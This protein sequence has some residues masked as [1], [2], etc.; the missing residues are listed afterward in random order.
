M[1]GGRQQSYYAHARYY[2]PATAQ[3]LSRDPA[4]AT[5][6]EPYSYTGDNPLNGTDPNGLVEVNTVPSG[7][8]GQTA[9]CWVSRSGSLDNYILENP[10]GASD[11]DLCAQAFP[12]GG[13]VPQSAMSGCVGGCWGASGENTGGV[14]Y[15]GEVNGGAYNS[16]PVV[17]NELG[18]KVASLICSVGL[19]LLLPET[20]LPEAV[21]YGID[22]GDA[23]FRILPS[24]K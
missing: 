20:R 15:P 5:T 19:T 16:G 1:F 3:F 18:N 11:T 9:T 4:A 24:A 23:V 14:N 17:N 6:R 12:Q 7:Y 8:R 10:T 21:H 13:A 2:D 22:A